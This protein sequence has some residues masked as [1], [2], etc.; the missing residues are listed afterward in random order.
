MADI[1]EKWKR[2]GNTGWIDLFLNTPD[3]YIIIDHK[4]YPETDA[5]KRMK[6]YILQLRM[7]KEI[8]EK[9]ADKPVIDTLRHLTISGLVLKL[10]QKQTGIC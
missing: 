7:Y 9:A 4:D 2:I 5:A 6:R 1:S 8:I 3:G 10:E